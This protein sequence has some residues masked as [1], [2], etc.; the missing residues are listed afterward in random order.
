MTARGRTQFAPTIS[1]QPWI[2]PVGWTFACG[3]VRRDFAAQPQ[4]LAQR[5]RPPVFFYGTM[6]ASS[7]TI[8]P[9]PPIES[10]GVDSISSRRF[11]ARH[12]ASPVHLSPSQ[13]PK[14]DR[15]SSKI[16][17]NSKIFSFF[18]PKKAVNLCHPRCSWC[19]AFPPPQYLVVKTP[20][21]PQTVDITGFVR[22]DEEVAKNEMKNEK[23]SKTA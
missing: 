19:A 17:K 22:V 21:T 20:Q 15:K 18:R 16:E 5:P 2:E 8:F 6:W 10:V 4:N 1:C 3:K 11:L 23:Q 14:N 7:P 9:P 13:T 12:F